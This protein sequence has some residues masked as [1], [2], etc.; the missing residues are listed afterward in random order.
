MYSDVAQWWSKKLLTSRL[1]VRVQP[2][3]PN[4]FIEVD[5]R[6]GSLL[7]FFTSV[8]VQCYT[9]R[10]NTISSDD[11][12]KADHILSQAVISNGLIF[13]AGQIHQNADGS[14][15]DGTVTEKLDKIMSNIDGILQ[16]GGSSLKKAVK[17]TIYSTDMAQMPELN[18]NYPK[19][20]NVLPA[21]EAIG[22]ASLP[23]G[24]TL[25]LSVIAEL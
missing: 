14:L 16:A 22:V 25:E 11:A 2:S 10:M 9:Y 7:L 6:N 12:P 20:F 23:L 24:A 13:V 19:Y 21:R 5:Y 15:F 3:E 4:E 18:E 1:L 8:R 17:V